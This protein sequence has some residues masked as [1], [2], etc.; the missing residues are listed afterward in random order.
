MAHFSDHIHKSQELSYLFPSTEVFVP[1][2]DTPIYD[3]SR[4]VLTVPRVGKSTFM[5]LGTTPEVCSEGRLTYFDLCF[6]DLY[7]MSS[8]RQ[9][10][11]KLLELCVCSSPIIENTQRGVITLC[12]CL[13]WVSSGSSRSTASYSIKTAQRLL[14]FLRSVAILSSLLLSTVAGLHRRVREIIAI[15]PVGVVELADNSIDNL[16]SPAIMGRRVG[17]RR[18]VWSWMPRR[19]LARAR[20]PIPCASTNRD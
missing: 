10:L 16:Q 1:F 11:G 19:N 5:Y 7:H 18:G 15:I 14:I 17:R 2:S 6:G 12:Y 9:S 20:V 4:S 13:S 8:I 3:Q